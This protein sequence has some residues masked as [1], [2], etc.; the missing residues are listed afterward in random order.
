MYVSSAG[1]P[2][3]VFFNEK[4]GGVDYQA[5]IL[6]GKIRGQTAEF[7]YKKILFS[8]E[9]GKR[10]LWEFSCFGLWKNGFRFLILKKSGIQ[11]IININIKPR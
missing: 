9:I 8:D 5:V 6:N 4:E 1:K 7:C 3:Q 2:N 11:K 10:F